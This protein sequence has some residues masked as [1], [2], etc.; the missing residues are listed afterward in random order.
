[1]REDFGR[2]YKAALKAITIPQSESELRSVL[3]DGMDRQSAGAYYRGFV[4]E[5]VDEF[6]LMA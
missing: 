1:M 2:V 5:V 4:E 6:A 3:A